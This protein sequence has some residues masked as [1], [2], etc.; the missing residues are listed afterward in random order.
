MPFS[1]KAFIDS[2]RKEFNKQSKILDQRRIDAFS[3]TFTKSFDKH[4]HLKTRYLSSNHELFINNEI[5][6]AIMTRTRLNIT[7]CKIEMMK[8]EDYFANGEIYVYQF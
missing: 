1:S 5:S 2:S 8:I 3:E 6:K 7:F 4:A